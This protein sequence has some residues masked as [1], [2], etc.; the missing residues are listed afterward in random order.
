[1]R[2]DFIDAVRAYFHARAKREV[3][4]ELPRE[5]HEGG[6]CGNLGQ[7]MYGTR[8]AAQNWEGKYTEMMT[9]AKIKQGAHGAWVFYHEERNV[10]AVSTATI[11]R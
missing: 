11:S 9:G 5:D 8:D 3:Y 1:V 4:A 10:R 6:M 7:A 2:S